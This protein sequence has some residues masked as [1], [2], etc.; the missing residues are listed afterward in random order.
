MPHTAKALVVTCMDFRFHEAIFDHLKEQGLTKQYDLY[1]IAG[2]QKTF[3]DEATQ[4]TA[5]KQVELSQKLHAITDVVLIAHWDCGAYGGST[6]FASA[7][8]QKMQYQADLNAAK[9]IILEKHA[10]LQVQ[11]ILAHIN[12]NEEISF[13]TIA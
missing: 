4:A 13:E 6:S 11:T 8:A 12:D 1:S 9:G 7:E 5:L 10:D 3:L 2:S